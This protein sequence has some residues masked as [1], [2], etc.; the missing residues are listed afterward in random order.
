MLASQLGVEPARVDCVLFNKDASWR[1]TP[2]TTDPQ[3][4]M[5]NRKKNEPGL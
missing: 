1:F 5:K 3:A 2:G 4:N